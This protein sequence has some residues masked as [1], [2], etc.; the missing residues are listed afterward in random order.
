MTVWNNELLNLKQ[1]AERTPYKYTWLL[2]ASRWKENP[3]PTIMR[4][5]QQ[6]IWLSDFYEWTKTLYGPDGIYRGQEQF[7]V[8]IKSKVVK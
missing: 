8:V 5:T 3:L 6:E 2:S 7:D 1:L 4:G